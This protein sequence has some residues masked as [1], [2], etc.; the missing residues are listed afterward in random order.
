MKV[1]KMK[2]TL[3]NKEVELDELQYE[4]EYCMIVA[5]SFVNDG[6]KLNDDEL[7]ELQDLYASELEQMHY[8]HYLAVAEAFY[9]GD[10]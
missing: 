1:P 4:D 3:N 2:Y 8:E 9:E 10:R 7:D 5:A 6:I